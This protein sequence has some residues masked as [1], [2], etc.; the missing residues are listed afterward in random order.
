MTG[1]AR[2]SIRSLPQPEAVDV[3][4]AGDGDAASPMKHASPKTPACW[5]DRWFLFPVFFTPRSGQHRS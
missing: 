2:P 3:P 5:R 4:L 1:A